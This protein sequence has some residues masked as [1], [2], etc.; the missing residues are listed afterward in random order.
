MSRVTSGQN[1]LLILCLTVGLAPGQPEPWWHPDSTWH[2]YHALAA[3][4]IDWFS[5]FDSAAGQGGYLATL[6]SPAENEF[7]FSLV[8]SNIYWF[9][10]PLTHR[11]AGPWLGGTQDFGALEPDSGWHWVTDEPMNYYNWSA[12][13]PDNQGDEDALHFGESIHVRVSTWND[14]NRSDASIRGFVRELSA[15]STTLGLLRMDSGNFAGYILFAP[16]SSRFSYLI[17]KKGRFVHLWQALYLPG[18]SIYLLENGGLLR[19]ARLDNPVFPIGGTGG[20][21][22]LIDWDGRLLWS[23]NYSSDLHCQHHDAL[24][25]PDGNVLMIAWEYKTSEEAIAAG[26]NPAL[27]TQNKLFPDHL[28][29]VDTSNDSI[30]WEWHVWDHLIQDYDSTKANYGVVRDHP[31]L[32]DIN[33]S[34]APRSRRGFPDWLHSNAIAYNAQFDQIVLCVHNFGE[35]WVIDHSTTSEEARGHTG[36]RYDQGG[37]ILYRWGN[38][39]AYRTGDSLDQQ[40]FNP[41]NCHWIPPGLPGAGH[42]LVFNNGGR[43]GYSTVDEFVPAS[44]STGAYPRPA[45]GTP[46][47]PDAPCWSYQGNPPSSFYSASLSSAQRLPNGNTFICLGDDGIL[48][49]VTPDG[50]LLWKYVNPVTDSSRLFQGDTVPGIPGSKFNNVFRA[51]LYPPSY[52]AFVGRNLTPGYPLERYST[53][54]TVGTAELRSRPEWQNRLSAWPNPFT[55]TLFI[56]PP[57]LPAPQPSAIRCRIYN[58]AGRLIL[59]L[60]LLS[61]DERSAVQPNLAALPAGVYYCQLSGHRTAARLRIVKQK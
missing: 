44:D 50:R 31:E 42:M 25:L 24:P 29:E 30:V 3:D 20:R 43:R 61:Y 28:V 32:V 56:F 12:G 34:A 19:A 5:A 16:M 7:V 46:F 60:P 45:P 13:Q 35:I 18:A 6:T 10:R 51:S 21:V 27:L 52:P 8:D 22:A 38:P 9:E 17:D 48:L 41:H 1:F 37:D 2:Y 23:F 59:E 39:A 26:R 36:G 54:Q 11:L 15:D 58:A 53:R 47:G 14:L 40:L 55:T 57:H 33:Y 49:E 4:S